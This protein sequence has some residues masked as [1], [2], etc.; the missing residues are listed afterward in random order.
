MYLNGDP[1]FRR[2]RRAALGVVAGGALAVG[3][4]VGASAQ[5]NPEGRDKA[6]GC[7][8][9]SPL[10]GEGIENVK[11]RINRL[12]GEL[13]GK[14]LIVNSLGDVKD[15]T[16]TPQFYNQYANLQLT[17]RMSFEHMDPRTCAKVGGEVV[18]HLAEL[19]K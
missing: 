1:I 3:L 10:P 17:D 2:R 6:P 7:E 18:A 13:A 16:N 8:H 9:V 15:A 12:G 11:Q 19:K 4:F 14:S 5:S